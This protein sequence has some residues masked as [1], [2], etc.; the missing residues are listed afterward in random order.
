MSDIRCL[1]SPVFPHGEKGVMPE[2]GKAVNVFGLSESSAAYFA[3][4]LQELT[5]RDCLIVEA[6]EMLCRS[7]AEAIEHLLPGRTAILPPRDVTFL[8]TAAAGRELT[9]RRLRALGD[10]ASGKKQILV[11]CTDALM[12]RLMDAQSFSKLC[13]RLSRGERHEPEDVMAR[14]TD[15]GYVRVQLVEA[16]GQCALRGGILD[17][18]PVGGDEA[19]RVEFFDDEIDSVR[20]FDVLTQRSLSEREGCTVYPARECILS[21]ADRLALAQHLRVKGGGSPRAERVIDAVT[22]ARPFEGEDALAPV[23]LDYRGMPQDYL[24]DPFVFIDLPDR[25]K[26]RG[27]MR[28][29]EF[30]E[31]FDIASARG[32]TLPEQSELLRPLS[33]A[34]LRLFAQCAVIT[35]DP[36]ERTEPEGM[37]GESRLLFECRAA[38]GYHAN[39]KDLAQDVNAWK[40]G[41]WRIALLG[42]GGARARRLENALATQGC[43]TEFLEKMPDEI[44]PGSAAILPLAFGRGFLFPSLKFAV[45]SESDVYGVEKKSSRAKKRAEDRMDVFTELNVGDYVVHENHGIGQYMGTVRLTSDGAVRDFLHIRY[46][47][48]DKLYVPTDQLSRIQKYIGSEGE[49]PRL[50]K[51]SGGEWQ[52]QKSRVLSSVQQIAKDLVKLYAQREAS[53]GFAFLPDTPW[54][55]EFEDNFPF[56]ET[57]DQLTAI[58]E[59]KRDMEKPRI[60]DRLLCGDV[61]YGKTEVALR[62]IF[63]CVMSGKQ[64][65]LLAPTTILVQQHYATMMDRFDGFPVRVDVL[66]RFKTAAEQKKI[67]ERLASGELDVV[68]GT[69]RVLAKDVSFKDLGLLVVDEEQR[70]GVTH[71]ERIKQLKKEVDVLTLTATPIP[72]TLHM[73]MVGIRDMSLLQSPPEERYPV[74]TYVAEY[75]ES[76]VRDAIHRELARGGQAFVLYNRVQTIESM[77]MTLR[78]L[79]PEAR[80]GV[81][82]GQ[83]P[84]RALEDVMLDFY[85][86]KFDVLLCTT[87]IEAGLDVPRCNTLIVCDADRF[88]LA[89]L[90]QLRGRVGRSNRLAY[91]YFTVKAGKLLTESA[92]RRLNAIREFTEFGS[93]FRVAMRDL[94]IRGAGNLLGSEQSGFMASVGYD[95]YVRMIEDSVRELK[96]T[97]AP[98]EI[99]TKAELG[100]DA[101]IPSDYMSGDLSRIEMY[102]KISHIRTEEDR[103]DVTEELIDRFGDPPVPVTNL[104][105]IALLRAV[106]SRFGMDSVLYRQNGV[107]MR[108]SLAADVDL[109]RIL[110]AVKGVPELR[111]LGGNPP[112]IQCDCVNGTREKALKKALRAMAQAS[113]AY[114]AEEKEA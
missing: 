57:P 8:R 38:R 83:M 55:K 23:L 73:S 19:V 24:R 7:T 6:N 105:D 103:E 106:C 4:A 61:G 94:E 13:L 74:Q 48:S 5:G 102:K 93:G 69:H 45:L 80:I 108:F 10:A 98:Q 72:R 27:E 86:G 22:S 39:V 79:L 66:S 2:N 1:I 15:A 35:S 20:T 104:L 65:V 87:I 88:G 96:G 100:V 9:L 31:M 18:F 107:Y 36:F 60:M 85:D 110:K 46:Q 109:V 3:A 43:T 25:V 81:G 29:M 113:R 56:E 17:V 78:R 114:D 71:K 67:L 12:D 75:S 14:L 92:D 47:G 89:Q 101:Y 42:G 84:E 99:D 11:T 21:P 50:N 34:L 64:A 53:E 95:M 112:A 44:R 59:I 82:H 76:L 70:F 49:A 97:P 111:V 90:Y 52:K 32:E 62:A 77:Y 51:L 68:V 40:R 16:T 28:A 37:A 54:Q 63:K 30:T 26:E 41:G 91:A 33:D 58:A